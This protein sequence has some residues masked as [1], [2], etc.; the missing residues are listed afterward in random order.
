MKAWKINEIMCLKGFQ[1]KAILILIQNKIMVI[2][3]QYS[4]LL[5]PPI[6]KEEQY[7]CRVFVKTTD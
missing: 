5:A 7:K 4:E 3:K 2:A 6:V 1:L